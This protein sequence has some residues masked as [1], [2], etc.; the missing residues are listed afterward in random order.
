M[1]NRFGHQILWT[2][3]FTLVRPF[4]R[5]LIGFRYKREKR[6]EGPAIIMGNHNLDIDA[7]LMGL[8]YGQAMR[9]VASEHVFRMGI[10]TLLIKLFFAPIVRMKGKTEIRTVRQIL[11]V[12]KSGGRVCIYPEGNRS[13]NGLTGEITQASASLARMAKCQ[14]ITYRIEGGYL[15]HPRWA[16]YGRRGPVNGREVGRYS[17]AQLQEMST[18]EVLA[19][20]RRDL[21]EDA[22]ARQMQSPAKYTGKSLAESIEAALYLCPACGQ[23][24]N[25]QSRGDRFFCWCG[26]DMRYLE[27]GMLKSMGDGDARFAT[28]TDWDLWQQS[29]TEELADRAQDGSIAQDEM[30]SLYQITPCKKDELIETGTLSIS[31]AALSCGATMFPISE[32]SDL[33]IVGLNTLVFET[34]SG[35]YYE[36]RS[37]GAYSALKYRR[38]FLYCKANP[39]L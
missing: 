39:N 14:L 23:I 28:V 24:G 6:I 27:T 26:L 7:G 9:V 12:I 21:H 17:A 11:N 36:I 33:A 30:L 22:Y 18:D 2:V 13:Y 8:S 35:N 16:K 19:L 29:M 20:I 1:R 4:V 31:R 3:F 37:K 5:P 34:K 32:I 10:L 25:I 38:F 15:K